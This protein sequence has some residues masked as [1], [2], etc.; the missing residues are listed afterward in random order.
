MTKC[1]VKLTI[2]YGS[3]E[4]FNTRK[5]VVNVIEESNFSNNAFLFNEVNLS[6]Y[7]IIAPLE[8]TSVKTGNDHYLHTVP[9]IR[10]PHCDPR[11]CGFGRVDH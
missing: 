9:S 6:V 7:L 8:K 10:T 4:T 3:S 1:R 11:D 2:N 5:A